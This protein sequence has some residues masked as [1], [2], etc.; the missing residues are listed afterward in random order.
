MEQLNNLRLE[1]ITVKYNLT[2]AQQHNQRLSAVSEE[3]K[4]AQQVNASSPQ[5]VTIHTNSQ[6]LYQMS[7]LMTTRNRGVVLSLVDAINTLYAALQ[8]EYFVVSALP[9]S[10]TPCSVDVAFACHKPHMS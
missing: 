2:V 7:A 6:L 3:L 4:I 9:A 10:S 8:Y 5:P 1:V